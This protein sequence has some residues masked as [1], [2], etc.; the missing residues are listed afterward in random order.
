MIEKLL[1]IRRYYESGATRAYAFR[2]EQLKKLRQS[3]LAHEKEL[4]DA[5]HADLKKSPEES[6]VTEVGFVVAEINNAI[7]NLRSWM[8]PEKVSTNLLNMP[9]GSRILREPLGVVL[10]IGPWNYPFQ[11]LI[12]PLV[13]AIAAGNC[14]VIKPSE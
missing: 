7:S 1:A 10:V 14:V 6:W 4:Y 11:L 12:N 13:G 5:L 3:I 2:K 8:E 9:S